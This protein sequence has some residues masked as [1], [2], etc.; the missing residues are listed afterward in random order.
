MYAVTLELV[1]YDNLAI[2]HLKWRSWILISVQT[3]NIRSVA[4]LSDS[5]TWP[6]QNGEPWCVKR[7]I[8]GHLY[9]NTGRPMHLWNLAMPSSYPQ[10]LSHSNYILFIVIHQLLGEIQ[11]NLLLS[12][13]TTAYS[14]HLFT[15]LMQCIK[16]MIHWYKYTSSR[17]LMHVVNK[18]ELCTG[19][20]KTYQP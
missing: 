18:S 11:I 10:L 3:G 17:K 1:K 13:H 20:S 6:D 7:Y 5:V 14:S 15:Y 9:L 2:V 8:Q 12:K 16:N 19:E 4:H